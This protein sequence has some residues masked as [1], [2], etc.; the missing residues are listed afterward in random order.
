MGW[1]SIGDEQIKT[2][3]ELLQLSKMRPWE[4][5]ELVSRYES[6][7]L[8]KA[9][10]IIRNENDAEEIVQDTFTKIYVH[11]DSF[12]PREGATFK[13]W[14]YRILCNT[15]YTYYQ[16]KK[17]HNERVFILD[18]EAEQRLADEAGIEGDYLVKDEVDRLLKLLPEN[19]AVVLRLQFIERWSQE[20]IAKQLGESVG[21]VKV[22]VH[23]AKQAFRRLR[24]NDKNGK[25]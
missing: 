4:F 16:N 15:A 12:V 13:S 23:R 25:L 17:R 21:A 3:E 24:H 6:A 8:R 18:P 1:F 11:A 10:S 5:T 2:D 7:F 20:D 9:R 19:F 22:R 14:A